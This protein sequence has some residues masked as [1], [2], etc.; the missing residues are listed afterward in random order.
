MEPALPI[1]VE[2]FFREQRITIQYLQFHGR[3]PIQQEDSRLALQLPA[4]TRLP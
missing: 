2:V 4:Q 1:H 3:V